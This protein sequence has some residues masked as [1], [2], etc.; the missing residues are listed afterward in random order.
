MIQMMKLAVRCF[1]NWI[2]FIICKK[3]NSEKRTFKIKWNQKEKRARI[4]GTRLDEKSLMVIRG[5]KLVLHSSSLIGWDFSVLYFILSST[6]I[7]KFNLQFIWVW[8][9]IFIQGINHFQSVLSRE[10]ELS[11][12]L[13]TSLKLGMLY[14]GHTDGGIIFSD[15]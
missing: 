6:R 7:M 11:V 15:D 5:S 14:R 2:F 8:N 12:L 9:W 13:H 4:D 10:M 1:A 3:S